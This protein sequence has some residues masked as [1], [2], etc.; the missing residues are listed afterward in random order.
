M[1][2][3]T[4]V[5][6]TVIDSDWLNDVNDFVYKDIGAPYVTVTQFGAV[7]NGV[8]NDTA[9]FTSARAAAPNGKY[10]IPP[11]TYIVDASPD[12]W[13][14]SFIAPYATTR[15]S[16]G[17]VIFDISGSFGSGWRNSS[18]TQRYLTWQHARTGKTIAIWSDGEDA[19]DSHRFFLPMDIRRDSHAFIMAPETNGGVTDFLLRRSAANV[20][21][22]GNRFSFGYTESMDRYQLSYATSASG[23]PGFD[24]VYQVVAGTTP[25]LA[26]PALRPNFGQGWTVQ[27]RAGGALKL[28][29]VPGATSHTETDETSGNTT[30]TITRSGQTMAGVT[31]NTMLDLPGGTGSSQVWAKNYGDL[32]SG[33]ALPATVDIYN[34]TGAT[35]N[36]VIGRL[37]VTAQSSGA[38]GSVR[39]SR[40]TFDGT[41]VTLTDLVNTL[42][43]QFTA[44]IALVGNN[45]QFQASY[46]GGLGAGYSLGVK[47][48]YTAAGR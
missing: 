27:T 37:L 7:G 48:E 41:T 14:D 29:M 35:R 33:A 44:T 28:S 25:T 1:T 13:S 31:M 4:F 22:F 16:I 38:V 39:E 5:T 11:G 21:P 9:A 42:P 45:L 18:N 24:A 15:L 10:L 3:K 2:S 17:G 46:A 26:F 30:R 23:A 43:A 34:G 6:G 32:V 12:V 20:D 19:G 47:I 8:A 36:M 40:F